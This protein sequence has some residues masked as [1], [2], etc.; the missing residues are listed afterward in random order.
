[1]SSWDICLNGLILQ[2]NRISD[3]YLFPMPAIIF[4][5]SKASEI[6][7]SCFECN[8]N[9]LLNSSLSNILFKQSGPSDF[10][11]SFSAG[12]SI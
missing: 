1:M 2:I 11:G 7:N 9:L 12:L 8:N 5:F 3:L 10:I 4:G 6:N